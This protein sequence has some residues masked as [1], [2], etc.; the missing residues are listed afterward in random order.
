MMKQ[1]KVNADFGGAFY[2]T[3]FLLAIGMRLAET[4]GDWLSAILHGFLSWGYVGYWVV[5]FLNK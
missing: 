3:G 5:E 1:V 2:G 4:G